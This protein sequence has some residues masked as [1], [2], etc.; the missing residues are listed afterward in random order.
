MSKIFN[1]DKLLSEPKKIILGGVEYN[2]RPLELQDVLKGV[3]LEEKASKGEL[4][5]A[6]AIQVQIDV[7]KHAIPEL[8]TDTLPVEIFQPLFNFILSGEHEEE[9]KS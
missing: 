5:Q 6:D 3:A 7:I 9:K 1:A 8:D 4:S 2:V